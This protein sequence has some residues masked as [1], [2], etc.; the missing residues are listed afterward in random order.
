MRLPAEGSAIEVERDDGVWVTAT[1]TGQCH[2][3]P[4]G[5]HV[6]AVAEGARLLLS[7][8]SPHVRAKP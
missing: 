3:H 6:L 8:A 1:V 5:W 7:I 4:G 2:L